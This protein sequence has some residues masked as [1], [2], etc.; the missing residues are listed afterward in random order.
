MHKWALKADKK[1]AIVSIQLC[2]VSYVK[3]WR[4]M[5]KFRKPSLRANI[6]TLVTTFLR[7]GCVTDENHLG[8]MSISKNTAQHIQQAIKHSL[9]VSNMGWTA[10]KWKLWMA[11]GHIKSAYMATIHTDKNLWPQ[12]VSRRYSLWEQLLK[13][14]CG[15]T[16]KGW[17]SFWCCCFLTQWILAII[18]CRIFSLPLYYP[19]I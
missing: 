9:I 5:P 18:L 17:Q 13:Y 3:V 4:F 11:S 14:V 7:T 19:K 10:V 1:V 2:K 12:H 15:T 6:S 16:T 8:N